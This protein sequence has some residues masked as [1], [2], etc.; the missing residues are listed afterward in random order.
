MGTGE[1]RELPL[2]VYGL[3]TPLPR[4]QQRAGF[5]GCFE[6]LD[7]STAPRAIAGTPAPSP[8]TNLCGAASQRCG[9]MWR[10]AIRM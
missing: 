9:P 6:S 5:T 2:T 7:F 1:R 4:A 8:S 3:L 10:A